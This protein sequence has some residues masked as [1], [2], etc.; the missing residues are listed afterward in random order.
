MEPPQRQRWCRKRCLLYRIFLDNEPIYLIHLIRTKNLNYDTRNA[1]TGEITLVQTEKNFIKNG[2]FLS[3]ATEW[4]KLDPNLN[5]HQ[6]TI[7]NKL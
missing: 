4:N 3:T 6:S 7:P 1:G 2:F 5:K